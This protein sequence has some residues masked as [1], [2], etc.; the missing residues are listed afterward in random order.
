MYWIVF[1]CQ[2]D[3][4]KKKLSWPDKK[5]FNYLLQKPSLVPTAVASLIH[6][7]K[8]DLSVQK[9]FLPKFLK[10]N[11]CPGRPSAIRKKTPPNNFKVEFRS[12]PNQDY[13]T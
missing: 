3:K 4:P 5:K 1:S 8:V 11:F 13:V 9:Q 7:K 12:Y 6:I 10:C 2:I